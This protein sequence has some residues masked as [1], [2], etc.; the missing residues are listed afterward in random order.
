MEPRFPAF[1]QLTGAKKIG[2]GGSGLVYAAEH[3]RWGAVAVKA[4]H[5]SSAE[6]RQ[7]FVSE[8]NLLRSLQHRAILRAFA[9]YTLDDG[10]AVIVTQ[11]CPNGDLYKNTDRLP[12]CERFTALGGIVSALEYLHALGIVHRDLKGENIL[13]HPTEGLKLSDLGLAASHHDS[14]RE[15]GGTLEYMA[16]EVIDNLGARIESDIYSLGVILYR[17]ATGELPFAAS[18]PLQVV[19]QKRALASALSERL[20][21][22]VSERFARVVRQCL[23]PDP[24]NRPKSVR[25]VAETLIVDQLIDRKDFDQRPIDD[26]LHH[27]YYSFLASFCRQE[28]KAAGDGVIIHHHQEPGSGL[29]AAV[30]DYISLSGRNV[31][32][33][34]PAAVEFVDGIEP[35]QIV[36]VPEYVAG[37]PATTIDLPELDRFACDAVLQKIFI[38]E[39]SVSTSERLYHLTSGNLALLRIV[40]RDWES[41]GLVDIKGG[42]LNVDA[43]ALY[44]Y[45]PN[46]DYYRL[47]REMLPEVAGAV[48]PNLQFLSADPGLYRFS[49]LGDL[50]RLKYEELT[51]LAGGG[52]ID[53][54]IR[55]LRRSY[56]R[57]YIAQHTP[58]ELRR[59]YHADWLKVTQETDGLEPLVRERLLFHHYAGADDHSQAV[60]AAVRLARM[61]QQRQSLDEAIAVLRQARSLERSTQ[62]R[63]RMLE[64]LLLQAE[65]YKVTGDLNR[66][67]TC[68]SAAI[69]ISRRIGDK[70]ASAD[71]YKRLGD[72]YKGKRDFRR[73][74]RALDRAVKYFGELGD[75]LELSHCFNNIGNICWIAGD[76]EGAE[77][78][79]ETAL[80]VQKRLNALKDTASTLSNLGTVKYLR[81]HAEEGIRLYKDSVEIKK[82]LNDLPELART[83]NNLSVAYFEQDELQ[84]AQEY[85]RQAYE[86]NLR[87]GAEEELMYN[88]ENFC[89]IEV[90]HGNYSETR[91]WAIDGLKRAPRDAHAA[92][93]TLICHL[94]NLAVLQGRFDKAAALI[95]AAK[96]RAERITDR[97]LTMNVAAVTGDYH[98]V[99]LNHKTALEAYAVALEHAQ[100]L[101]YTREMASFL[102][103]RAHC[104]RALQRPDTEVTATHEAIR[105]LLAKL[106]VKRERF[107]FLLELADFHLM[108]GRLEAC[109]TTLTQAID[110]PDFDGINALR[111]RLYLLRGRFELERENL[112]KAMMLLNDAVIGAKQLATPESIWPS[113]M[114]LG[115]C[116]K[117]KN[118][119]ERALKYFIEAFSLIRD[120]A[121]Y[122]PSRSLRKLYLSDQLKLRL[123]ERLEEMSALVA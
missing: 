1:L 89:E 79:Y 26:Y 112:P 27:H 99:L 51:K 111:P 118:D 6:Y 65:L 43:V 62:D 95:A 84:T 101:S 115:E 57:E 52:W 32:A 92:R 10:R 75:E 58:T 71:A 45:L 116:S 2:A 34:T 14:N 72:I 5:D 49:E 28:L 74:N 50:G 15:R 24:A 8:Y 113:L 120:T 67:L 80:E 55:G 82:R 38:K 56:F 44:H 4:A 33:S 60:A 59:L 47:V 93:G 54:E 90:R 31:K 42:R 78:N 64:L 86:I 63:A 97:M 12:L 87:L 69:R 105:P 85:L 11:L 16:P 109:E 36:L 106:S 88:F 25:E 119:F 98:R 66:S 107:D 53:P 20:E 96:A 39:L 22:A 7:L 48:D 17:V 37:S 117:R 100:Q 13:V 41:Q 81:G 40:L 68:L 30:S 83:Y 121:S 70:A 94:A 35:R 9:Y 103:R 21:Q 18:D 61:F 46:D 29:E 114:Y 19:S 104:Q 3:P 91:R 73:G 77:I 76:L 122:V 108:A 102:I 23:D 123:G 110:F